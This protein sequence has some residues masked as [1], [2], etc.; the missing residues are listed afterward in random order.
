MNEEREDGI[1]FGEICHLVKKR[2]WAILLASVLVTAAAVM[3]VALFLNP[4]STY[5]SMTFALASPAA[6]TQQYADGTPFYY[7][8]IISKDALNAAKASDERFSGVDIEEMLENDDISISS[9]TDGETSSLYLGVYT[10]RVGGRY[11]ADVG[12]AGAFIAAVADEAVAALLG[13]AE[14]LD[15]SV[16]SS[17]YY[18][19]A[20]EERLSML[21]QLRT[22]LITSYDTWIGRYS[23]AYSVQVGDESKTLGNYRA[24]A[25]VILGSSLQSSLEHACERGGYGSFVIGQDASD[26]EI[27]T[28]VTQ[29]R[30]ELKAEYA[31]NERIIE[32]FKDISGVTGVS[33]NTLVEEYI[34]RNATIASQLGDFV[35]SETDE[36]GGTL[37]VDG[38]KAFLQTLD[39]QYTALSAAADT[40]KQVTTAI[41]ESNTWAT[42]QTRLPEASGG[43]SVVLVGVAAFIVAFFVAA[44]IVCATDYPKLRAEQAKAA[45]NV[46][47]PVQDEVLQQDGASQEEPHDQ[48]GGE[49]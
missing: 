31:L 13:K 17:A 26:S 19:A 33:G 7:R 41:Y 15:Y 21:T 42:Y 47:K 27:Q 6:S 34:V 45:G 9:A 44:V 30:A 5:Y 46:Q 4:G 28:A 16:D 43:T 49:A 11:F 22:T 40:L 37:N 29:Y 12:T 25:G 36:G 24:E 3:V 39:A 10:I 32:S 1:T 8:N 20:L 2:I 35:T 38:V 23:S 48:T 14:S 18:A